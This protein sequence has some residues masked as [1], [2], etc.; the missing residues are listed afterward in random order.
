MFWKLIVCIITS[1]E[2]LSIFHKLHNR[3]Y[4]QIL[5]VV[6][7]IEL[8]FYGIISQAFLTNKNFLH[9]KRRQS[10]IAPSSKVLIVK[11]V[12][13]GTTNPVKS[14]RE[15]SNEKSYI[16][17]LP[18]AQRAAYDTICEKN[19][20]IKFFMTLFWCEK[21]NEVSEFYLG[22]S[23]RI[24][25]TGNLKFFFKIHLEASNQNHKEIISTYIE[26]AKINKVE[27][28]RDSWIQL[29]DIEN[30]TNLI[31]I[32]A[33]VV[34]RVPLDFD[35]DPFEAAL[36]E[37]SLLSPLACKNELAKRSLYVQ[38]NRTSHRSEF[39]RDRERVIHAKSFRRLVDKAQVFT[40]STGDHFRTRMTHSQEVNQI[41]RGIAKKLNLNADL[42]EAIALAHDIGHTPFGH[43][44]ERTLNR[45][46]IGDIPIFEYP[47][48]STYK[49]EHNELINFSP[50]NVGILEIGGFKH[51]KQGVRVLDSLEEKYIEHSGLDLS[52]QVLEGILKHSSYLKHCKESNVI[53]GVCQNFECVREQCH[54][55]NRYVENCASKDLHLNYPYPTTLEGQIVAIAD[56]IA[57]RGH[58]LDDALK[59]G[60]ISTNEVIQTFQEIGI[61]SI[62]D[63]LL[64]LEKEILSFK[65]LG[66]VYVDESDLFR[67]RLVPLIISHFIFDVT[68]A[69]QEKMNAFINNTDK[70][71]TYNSE[72]FLRE[73]L[74]SF[75]ENGT[76]YIKDLDNM[77]TLK[78]ISSVNVSRFD[79]KAETVVT[80]LFREYYRN[81]RLLPK[82][83]RIRLQNKFLQHGSVPSKYKINFETMM[84]G[85][86]TNIVN[87]FIYITEEQ[88]RDSHERNVC[89][90]C[91]EIL[92]RTIADLIG[93]MTD[94]YAM[95]E[96]SRITEPHKF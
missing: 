85:E 26:S 37:A 87:D 20:D 83:T 64:D 91:R 29:I 34:D 15:Y 86:L 25:S 90:V 10:M 48:T 9:K 5:S 62:S 49:N 46:L 60:L 12:E 58:D 44:G 35:S 93:G 18:H 92:S 53:D 41:S 21:S 38:N 56:E 89:I 39:Q 3:S 27:L 45:I 59:I 36:I 24:E 80:K 70:F 40:S 57:Q 6:L 13:N 50:T 65:K 23:H 51:N 19:S 84:P 63:K 67:A 66:R 96:Y 75:T 47:T 43:Q 77:I 82:S 22:V 72:G 17:N 11:M 31:L 30:S 69:S 61:T 8:L 42:T 71:S 76:K 4:F 16:Y 68:T 14:V 55:I 88:K 1:F 78:V 79:I 81:P 28:F 52:H 32:N 94:N 54:Y 73:M 74:I 2:D 95:T 7:S 33:P